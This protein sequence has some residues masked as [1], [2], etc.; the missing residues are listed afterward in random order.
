MHLPMTYSETKKA[1][2]TKP[3][4]SY[5]MVLSKRDQSALKISEMPLSFRWSIDS[6]V[7]TRFILFRR[8]P[9]DTWMRGTKPHC[10]SYRR[11]GHPISFIRL[12]PSLSSIQASK[13]AKRIPE[14]IWRISTSIIK[15]PPEKRYCTLFSDYF[16]PCTALGR[17][18]IQDVIPIHKRDSRIELSTAQ[19]VWLPPH[20]Y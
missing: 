17:S 5:P 13:D 8:S 9:W 6:L 12:A 7:G 20:L 3:Q 16:P 15:R 18:R 19:R 2:V 14:P 1:F 11:V 10:D 4:Y